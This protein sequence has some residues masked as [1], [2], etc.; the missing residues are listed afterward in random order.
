MRTNGSM[1]HLK[2]AARFSANARNCMV[3]PRVP[4]DLPQLLDVSRGAV[5]A[6]GGGGEHG[7]GQAFMG[8]S[9]PAGRRSPARGC[10]CMG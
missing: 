3:L 7:I 2:H 9:G 10:F 4:F 1:L 8:G 5:G 6:A